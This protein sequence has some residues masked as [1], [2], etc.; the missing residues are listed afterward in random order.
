[1]GRLGLVLS[2]GGSRAAYQV[3]VVRALSELGYT[4]ESSIISGFSAGAINAAYLACEVH[5]FQRATKNLERFWKELTPDKVFYTDIRRLL[6]SGIRLIWDL[7]FGGIHRH[8]SVRS[9][10]DTAPL[11]ELLTRHISLEN[12]RKN[13]SSGK[14][15]A[16]SMSATDYTNGE[17][18]SFFEC[19]EDVPIWNRKR[20]RAQ[21]T[22]IS[23]EHIMASAALPILFPPVAVGDRFYGDG[24][25]RNAAP[26]SSAIHLGA[27]RLLI[28]GVRK[29]SES[30]DRLPPNQFPS[31]GRILSVIL[32]AILLDTT[33]FD[34]ERL[35]RINHTLQWIPQETRKQVS[36]KPIEFVWITPSKDI[37]LLAKQYVGQLPLS[38]RYL[39]RGLGS[40]SEFS[41]IASYLLFDSGFCSR[42]IELGYQDTMNQ[43]AEISKLFHS[44]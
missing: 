18:V 17:S 11:N 34:V 32:N 3:G 2:G 31:L 22:S 13:I 25:L 23:V 14:L 41:E 26:L 20:R 30:L 16:L 40:K 21:V 10:L 15:H 42:L 19:R 4:F 27:D 28:V 39:L 5:D 35:I 36:L 6:K 38:I 43:K 24:C 1:M 37:G 8:T 29:Q 12:L 9:L 7:S 44:S 33:D